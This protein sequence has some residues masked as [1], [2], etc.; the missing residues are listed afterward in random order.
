MC[1]A[2][3]DKIN[4]VRVLVDIFSIDGTQPFENPSRCIGWW[5]LV[6]VMLHGYHHGH[7]PRLILICVTSVKACW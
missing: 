4:T 6:M 5:G 3:S 1:G 7:G 2:V